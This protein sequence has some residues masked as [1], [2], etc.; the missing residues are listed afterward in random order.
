MRDFEF[1]FFDF[2]LV[3]FVVFLVGDVLVVE[4]VVVCYVGFEVLVVVGDVVVVV[5]WFIGEV[6]EFVGVDV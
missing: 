3:Y 2:F 5:V 4:F 6:D 1:V